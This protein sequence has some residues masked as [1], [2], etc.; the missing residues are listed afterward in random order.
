[1][2]CFTYN[3]PA[4]IKICTR[5]SQLHLKEWVGEEMCCREITKSVL[6]ARS[7]GTKKELKE[8]NE[9]E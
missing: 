7:K 1:M 4:Q 2:H 5:Q 3:C 9:T 8:N 6:R